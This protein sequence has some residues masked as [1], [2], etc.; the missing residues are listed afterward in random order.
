MCPMGCDQVGA[1]L[2]K[3]TPDSLRR[4]LAPKVGG[5]AN[6]ASASLSLPLAWSAVFSSVS[7]LAGFSGHSD[8]CAA[9]AAAD[10][11]ASGAAERGTPALSIQWG[12]WSSVGAHIHTP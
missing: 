3:Q 7:A 8:Y 2:L 1:R 11:L 9:N 4:V 6:L 10:A 5:A 12:A